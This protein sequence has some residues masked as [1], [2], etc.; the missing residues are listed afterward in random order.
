MTVI[1]DSY[2]RFLPIRNLET[3]FAVMTESTPS[4]ARNLGKISFTY[5]DAGL[6]GEFINSCR[7]SAWRHVIQ[8]H[9]IDLSAIVDVGCSYGSWAE[10]YRALGFGKLCGIDPNDEAI[11]EA[12]KVF[13]EAHCAFASS[14]GRYYPNCTTIGCNGVIVHIIEEGE[15]VRFLEDIAKRLTEDGHLIYSVINADYYLS[16]GRTDWVGPNACV[17]PL[18]KHREFAALAGLQILDEVG[19][20]IEPWAARDLEYI[21]S[22]KELRDDPSLYEIFVKLSQL[23]RGHNTAP[24]SEV[25]FVAQRR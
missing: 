24:F 16:A 12:R 20:F 7:L 8:K 1:R 4:F 10:N 25:L 3:K 9:S 17:R 5:R 21:A 2:R 22:R 13:D 18:Q 14:L 11:R 19:T 23:L 15:T 6:Y